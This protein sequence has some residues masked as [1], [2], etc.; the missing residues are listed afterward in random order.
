MREEE[1][2]AQV[3]RE[4]QEKEAKVL[5]RARGKR[6]KMDATGMRRREGRRRKQKLNVRRQRCVEQD[7]MIWWNRSWWIRIEHAHRRRKAQS[8]ASS[9]ESG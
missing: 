9:Q 5:G 7:T 4:R 3:A 6:E 8:L 1:R 2:R